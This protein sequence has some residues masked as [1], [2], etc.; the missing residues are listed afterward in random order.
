[1]AI[2]SDQVTA[3]LQAALGVDAGKVRPRGRAAAR[4]ARGAAREKKRAGRFS[5]PRPS[6]PPV[7]AAERAAR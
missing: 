2:P 1:M 4:P 6:P 5:R 7:P 3:V